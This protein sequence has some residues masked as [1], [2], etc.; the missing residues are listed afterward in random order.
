MADIAYQNKDIASKVTGEALI[1][2]SLRAFG[3]PHLKI[4]GILPT[5]LPV[6]ESNELRLDNLFLLS[7][8]SLAIIDYESEY[9][10]ENFIKYLNY[11][12]RVLR[13]YAQ[14][15][16]LDTLKHIRIVVI[17]TADVEHAD[18]I[19]DLGG[20]ILMT[21]SAFLVRQ[22]TKEIYKKL[23]SKIQNRVPLDEEELI[24]MMILPL[25]VKGNTQKQDVILKTI[26]LAK[27]IPDKA[28]ALRI[29]A[30][31]LTFTD[32]IIDET[33]RDMIK[34]EMR[35]TQI[36]Q[37]IF[38]EGV[39][40]EKRRTAQNMY[41]RGFSAEDTARLVEKSLSEVQGWYAK[42][43]HKAPAQPQ[44]DEA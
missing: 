21:E 2:K 3:L 26:R 7:D 43:Q 37:M 41:I 11:I 13:R 6:I 29:L 20:F 33:N 28:Q 39:E 15:K 16:K 36:E 44:A 17:Y 35:M 10:K 38:N 5:N 8:G 9:D 12:A 40:A 18:T 25:T 24:Q 30:G 22:D 19:Y 14:Q 27:Q 42:W 23:V 34:E 31:I 32:K 4:T 1:G